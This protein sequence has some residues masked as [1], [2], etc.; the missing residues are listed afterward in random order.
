MGKVDLHVHSRISDGQLS[1]AE[2]IRKSA[3]IGVTYLGLADHDSVDGILPALNAAK[4]FPRLRII[5]AV[6]I[7]TDV[8]QGEAH[9]LGYFLDYG[10]AELLSSLE[11]LRRSRVIRAQKMIAK[12][13]NLGIIISWERVQELA[14]GSSI[15]RP[16]IAQAMLEKGYTSAFRD[17]FTKYIGREGPAYVER[18]KISPEE[19]V[20]LILRAHGLPVLAH[21]FTVPDVEA[22]IIQLKGAGMVGIETYYDSYTAEQVRDLLGL[23]LKYDLVPTGGSD[24][25]GLDEANETMIGAVHVPIESVQRLMALVRKGTVSGS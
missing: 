22:M 9:V 4:A 18:E 5:P 7:S 17:A 21:P 19:A 11:R 1:P 13:A 24:Y 14:K 20:R 6:E 25:H 16:H 2:L 23:A 15:G 12:L 8:P 3:A 10:N